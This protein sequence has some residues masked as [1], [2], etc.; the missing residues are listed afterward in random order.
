M[1][2]K[3]R[4]KK[5]KPQVTAKAQVKT[6]VAPS[7][8]TSSATNSGTS[9]VQTSTAFKPKSAVSEEL[10]QVRQGDI[11]RIGILLVAMA[12]LFIILGVVNAHSSILQRAGT[13]LASVMAI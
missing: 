10:L 1:G 12:V 6:E 9:I 4:H 8:V 7:L 3:S 2:Q 11:R 13:H 5:Q